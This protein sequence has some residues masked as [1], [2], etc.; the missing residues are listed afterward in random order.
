VVL[1]C[2]LAL[3]ISLRAAKTH[4]VIIAVLALWVLWLLILPIWLG[5]S[6]LSGVTPPPDWFR[7]TNPVLVVYAPYA[8]PAYVTRSDVPL[9][10]T[11]LFVLPAALVARTL[12]L[13][14]RNAPEPARRVRRLPRPSLDRSR[15]ARWL[16]YLPG[17]SLDGNPILWREWH[18]NR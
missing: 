5:T 18:R 8:W 4:E 3:A 11:G 10:R 13:V 9:F 12:A 16:T 15:P 17:P 14:R 2:S 7:K 1:G 6:T